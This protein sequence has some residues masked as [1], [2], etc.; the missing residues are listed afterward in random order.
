M[1]MKAT[2]TSAGKL[3]KQTARGDAIAICPFG[4]P[5]QPCNIRC[6]HLDAT[7]PGVIRLTCGG[8][9][10]VYVDCGQEKK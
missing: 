9:D 10:V 3:V 1:T 5:H 6:P 7:D 4:G 2:I 8:T